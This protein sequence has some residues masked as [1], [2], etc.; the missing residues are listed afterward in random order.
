MRLHRHRVCGKAS[1]IVS[2]IP[3]QIECITGRIFHLASNEIMKILSFLISFCS[4]WTLVCFV[5]VW[6]AWAGFHA[7]AL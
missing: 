4:N 3:R 6:L 2:R 5:R 7:N 1:V